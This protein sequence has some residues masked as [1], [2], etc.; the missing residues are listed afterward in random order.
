ML[1][2]VVH[3]CVFFPIGDTYYMASTGQT[4]HNSSISGTSTDAFM[5]KNTGTPLTRW[6]KPKPVKE[7]STNQEKFQL[8]AGSLFCSLSYLEDPSSH[9]WCAGGGTITCKWDNLWDLVN[10]QPFHQTQGHPWSKGGGGTVS[11][12]L[13]LFLTLLIGGFKPSQNIHPFCFHPN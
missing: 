10:Y 9:K 4:Q 6:T 13:N 12:L 3:Y 5:K 2:G 1:I 7:H 8:S 11:A